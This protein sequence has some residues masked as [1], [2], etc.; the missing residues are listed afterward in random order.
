MGDF[1]L[2]RRP[3]AQDAQAGE[4]CNSNITDSRVNIHPLSQIRVGSELIVLQGCELIEVLILTLV[5]KV[6]EKPDM[7][8]ILYLEQSRLWGGSSP[9][10]LKLPAQDGPGVSFLTQGLAEPNPGVRF[11]TSILFSVTKLK[12]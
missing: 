2:H 3:T 9:G 4:G 1:W 7:A 12:K 6:P 10:F 11:V 5:Q 8:C